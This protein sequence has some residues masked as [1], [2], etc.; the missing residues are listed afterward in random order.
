MSEIAS[1]RAVETATKAPKTEQ[2]DMVDL[3]RKSVRGGTTTMIAKAVSTA[4]QLISTITLARL[5]SPDDYGM[6][7]MVIAITSFAGLF[8]DLGISAAV[9]QKGEISHA[10]MSNL[11]WINIAMGS[12]LTV[13]MACV[14]PAISWF[15]DNPELTPLTI[16]LSPIFIVSSLGTQHGALLQ[17]KLLFARQASA[18]IAGS[19]FGLLISIVLASLDYGYW[20]LAWGLMTG[21]CVT[22]LVLFATSTFRPIAWTRGADMRSILAFG[23]N[24]TAFD[25]V[26]YF[27]RNLDNIVIGRYWGTIQLGFYSRAYSLMM[28]PIHA[29]RNPINAVAFPALSRLQAH[30]SQYRTYYRKTAQLLAFATMPTT[31]Y[32]FIASHPLID[33]LL[34]DKW[35]EVSAIFSILA[36]AAFI[37]PVSGLR[38]TVMLSTGNGRRYAQWGLMNATCVSIGFLIGVRWGAIGVAVSYAFT[39]YLL[40]FPSLVF[41]FSQSPLRYRDFFQPISIPAVA[42]IAAVVLCSY[43]STQWMTHFLSWQ[44]AGAIALVFFPSYLLATASLPGGWKMLKGIMCLFRRKPYVT[45]PTQL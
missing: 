15:Y 28:M 34:G 21:N 36:V 2:V 6:I 39:N 17:R 3:K 31:G 44:K 29:I 23:A 32:L 30:P 22:T 41:A 45:L 25:L 11:F 35:I 10:Q 18:G 26:N 7:A 12:L 9:I 13:L 19:T 8:R 4:I 14:S 1:D 20:S 42:S 33:V 38:G 40:L 43:V 27:H 37:Q 5:L 24:V 16:L